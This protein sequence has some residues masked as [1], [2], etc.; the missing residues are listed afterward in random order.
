MA[1]AQVPEAEK[2]R[3]REKM[4]MRRREQDAKALQEKLA[5]SEAARLDFERQE[6]GALGLP[7]PDLSILTLEVSSC[8]T[9]AGS[10]RSWPPP[11]LRAWN[12]SARKRVCCRGW[13]PLSSWLLGHVELEKHVISRLA[14]AKVPL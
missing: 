7:Y 13:P 14:A 1:T 8:K 11:R 4:E 10:K 5:A 9:G 12:L 6:A 2:A 3:L